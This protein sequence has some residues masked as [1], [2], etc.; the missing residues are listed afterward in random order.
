[1]IARGFLFLI[2]YQRLLI[3]FTV[4]PNQYNPTQQGLGLRIQMDF[5]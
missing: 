1:M 3:A 5:V 4:L 2:L